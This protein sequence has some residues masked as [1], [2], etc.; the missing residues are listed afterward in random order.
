MTGGGYRPSTATLTDFIMANMTAGQVEACMEGTLLLGSRDTVISGVSIDSRTLHSGD[1][2]FAIRGVVNNGHNYIPSAISKG[3]LGAVVDAAYDIPEKYPADRVLLRVNDTHRALKDLAAEVRR[4]WAGSLVAITGSMGKTTTK[5]FA[6]ILLQAKYN[7][8]RSPGNYNNLFGLPLS[9]FKLSPDDHIGIFEMGMS[10][11]GE[12]AQMCRIAD[13]SVGIITNIAP[14]HLESMGTMAEIARAKGELVE[15]LPPHGALI[16][17]VDEEWSRGIAAHF[18]GEKITFGLS[19]HAQVRADEITVTGTHETR[20]RI[21]CAGISRRTVIPVAGAHFV[22]NTL[23]AIALALHFDLTFD[24]VVEGLRELRQAPMRG[25]IVPFKEGFT[26]IDDSYNSNPE[27]LKN[28]IQLLAKLPS[29]KRRILVAGE[30]LELG[31]ESGRLHRECGAWAAGCGIEI[32]VG[33]QGLAKE[34]AEGAVAAGATASRVHFF[35]EINPA[36]DFV[37]R[38]IQP[39]DLLLI[40]GSRGIHLEKMVQALRSHYQEQGR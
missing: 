11:P 3:A 32:V 1:L 8:Y 5:D 10:A 36:I 12:I 26:I 14:V 40:K 24:Q 21:H 22:V 16:F 29:F 18:R 17:N 27:A 4:Q 28:M 34:I 23:P 38:S 37:S 20:F 19:K 7:V 25:Q 9:I 6:A 13:P 35:T 31:P 2:F 33:V 15:A 39:G 30:M